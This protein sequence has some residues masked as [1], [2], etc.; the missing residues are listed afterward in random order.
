MYISIQINTYT[1]I[2]IIQVRRQM[3][4]NLVI[5]C[6]YFQ[7]GYQIKTRVQE[8]GHGCIYLVQKAGALQ[9]SPTDSFSKRELIECARSVMEKVNQRSSAQSVFFFNSF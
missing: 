9:L 1:H 4:C 8:L 3:E 2:H 5:T 7:V 6:L